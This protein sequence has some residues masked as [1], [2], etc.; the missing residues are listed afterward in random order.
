M[1]E[2]D[3]D[4][5]ADLILSIYYY[6]VNFGPLSRGSAACG[7]I[8]MSG[9]LLAVG[10]K[11]TCPIKEGMQMD[12]EA[13]LRPEVNDFLDQ[14]R[15]WL[16]PSLEAFVMQEHWPVVTETLPNPRM[17]LRALAPIPPK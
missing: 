13:I 7:L 4:L 12:W 3:V 2:E 1:G 15:P 16:Y 11:I 8:V 6:W 5:V 17:S 9:L 14:L 10:M